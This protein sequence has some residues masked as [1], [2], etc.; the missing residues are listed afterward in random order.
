MTHH[1]PSDG[2]VQVSI[3]EPGDGDETFLFLSE[4]ERVFQHHPPS[5]QGN[6]VMILTEDC[7]V[8]RDVTEEVRR[9]CDVIRAPGTKQH[10]VYAAS[11]QPLRFGPG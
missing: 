9:V 10:P 3:Q 8:H 4:P 6:V 1:P 5:V 7:D 2:R 11:R